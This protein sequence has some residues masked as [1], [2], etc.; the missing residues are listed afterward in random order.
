MSA[1]SPSLFG[2]S[3]GREKAGYGL[4]LFWKTDGLVVNPNNAH[5]NPSGKENWVPVRAVLNSIHK[6]DIHYLKGCKSVRFFRSADGT[7]SLSLHKGKC[8]FPTVPSL[9]GPV[10]DLDMTLSCMYYLCMSNANVLSHG[11][12]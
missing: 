10:Q 9:L 7:P 12:K 3:T 1:S 11:S 2:I 5:S 6:D 8:R 4:K